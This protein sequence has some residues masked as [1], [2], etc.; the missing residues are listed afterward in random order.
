MAGQAGQAGQARQQNCGAVWGSVGHEMFKQHINKLT[1]QINKAINNKQNR[2]P[3]GSSPLFAGFE[4]A[5]GQDPAAYPI[6]PRPNRLRDAYYCYYYYYYHV[7]FSLLL[8]LLSLLLLLLLFFFFFFLLD[9]A[10]YPVGPR[11]TDFGT[12]PV[13]RTIGVCGKTLLQ[14]RIPSGILAF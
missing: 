4:D 14:R 12:R 2:S 7:L 9:P 5:A 13:S 11:P 8:L 3:S 1:K 6:G 10:A